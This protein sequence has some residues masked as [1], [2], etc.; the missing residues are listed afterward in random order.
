MRITYHQLDDSLMIMEHYSGSAW[1]WADG[2]WQDGATHKDDFTARGK[3]LSREE[4]VK[5]NLRAAT[6]ALDLPLG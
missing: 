1:I 3:P 4:F 6:A 5:N 2:K